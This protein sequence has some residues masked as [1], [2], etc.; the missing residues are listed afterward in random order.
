MQQ[1]TK[2]SGLPDNLIMRHD[3]HFV[4]LIASKTSAPRIRMIPLDRIEPN[5]RQPRSE[6]GDIQE[7]MDSIKA[8][9]VLEPIIVRPKGEKFEIIAGERRFVASKNLG[10]KEIPCIEMTVDDQEAM[11]ISLIEN[12]Q[13]KDLDIFEEADGLKALMNLYGYSHQE[14]ADKIGKARSTITEIISVSRIPFDLRDKLKR[15]GVTS[16][17][18]I[19]EIAK[20]ENESLMSQVVER[21]IQNRLTRTDTRDLTR[22]F[23]EKENQD[24]EKPKFFVFNYVPKENKTFK[25][26]IEFKKQVVT[27]QEL[28][29]ILENI[30][31]Q[32]KE[33]AGQKT[34]SGQLK[35]DD[36]QEK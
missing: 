18:T 31:K 9:G 14:V 34:G 22:L 3:P 12:L 19:I 15:A 13:R 29:N 7:L 11:E 17:S 27:R 16:R 30:I 6:L 26:R 33:E 32:L 28:I 35:L 24:T 36:G 21:I 25:L 10:L 4:E 2:K 20:L 23:K 5:P 1:K 8:K